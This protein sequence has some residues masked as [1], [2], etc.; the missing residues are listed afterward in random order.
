MQLKLHWTLGGSQPSLWPQF[1]HLERVGSWRLLETLYLLCPK[2]LIILWGL[3]PTQPPGQ[4]C[5]ALCSP[6]WLGARAQWEVIS[7]GEPRGWSGWRHEPVLLVT[8]YL[9]PALQQAGGWQI[10]GFFCPR[11]LSSP[12][13]LRLG[14]G[15]PGAVDQHSGKAAHGFVRIS[16]PKLAPGQ[17]HPAPGKRA[18]LTSPGPALRASGCPPGK[19]GTA[20]PLVLP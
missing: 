4:P 13:T 1:P 19:E 15:T 16:L 3:S 5:W 11:G 6:P 17:T 10:V 18:L 2:D 14:P 12:P 8:L 7:W 9:W 20:G